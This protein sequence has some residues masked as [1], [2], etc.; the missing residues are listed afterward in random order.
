MAARYH[1]A[2]VM[3]QFLGEYRQHFHLSP[4]QRQVCEHLMSCRTSQLEAHYWQ[5]DHCHHMQTTYAACR[6]RHCPR[7]QYQEAAQW[8]EQQ[9]ESVVDCRYFHL[10]F[11]LPGEVVQAFNGSRSQ[12]YRQLFVSAWQSISEFARNRKGLQGQA[13]MTCVLHTWGQTLTEH[14]HLHC[15]VPG[16]VLA[17][18]GQ[19]RE[20]QQEYLFPVKALSRKFRGHFLAGA[21]MDGKSVPAKWVVYSKHCLMK[22]RTILSYLGRYIRKIAFSE[23]RIEQVDD[24]TVCFRYLDYRDNQSKSMALSGVEFLRRWLSHVLPKGFVRVRHYGFL[25]NCCRRKK[26]KLIR[27]Y[28]AQERSAPSETEKTVCEVKKIWMCTKCKKGRMVRCDIEGRP[29]RQESCLGINIDAIDIV[30]NTM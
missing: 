13:G 17:K 15:L 21:K 6:N 19:W 9:Q 18:D 7:C 24:T 27:E 4:Q 22:T 5:C 16:G 23:S 2:Q 1:V 28:Q 10:V 26:V 11:T 29:Y 30:M 14:I 25:A 3:Q 12:L 8:V 20:I